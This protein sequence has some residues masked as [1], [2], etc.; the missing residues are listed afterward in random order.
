MI[1]IRNVSA[2]F[3]VAKSYPRAKVSCIR[4]RE[5]EYIQDF[6]N[7]K[8]LFV[9][10]APRDFKSRRIEFSP[11][12]P[13]IEGELLPC[14]KTGAVINLE[15]EGGFDW[16]NRRFPLF[17]ATW[18]YSCDC[19]CVAKWSKVVKRHVRLGWVRTPL[20]TLKRILIAENEYENLRELRETIIGYLYLNT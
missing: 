3:L 19:E 2:V 6:L 13:V 15:L 16:I 9:L 7:A 20:L 17:S 11:L 14:A 4:H 1:D 8:R 10:F 18:T 5:T 12:F